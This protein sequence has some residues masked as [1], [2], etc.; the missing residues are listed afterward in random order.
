[1]RMMILLAALPLAACGGLARGS[2]DGVKA[3]SS[4][5]G[6]SR[7]FQVADF[8]GVA[9]EGVDDVD[10]RVGPT[11]SVRADGPSEEL[12]KLNIRKDGSTLRVGRE[13][14]A[15]FNWGGGNHKGVKVHVTMPAIASASVA[16]PG[17]LTVDRVSADSFD[18]S[19]AGPG[20][21]TI[22]QIAAKSADLSVAGPGGITIKGQ[23]AKAKLSIA[24]PGDIH[25]EGLKL[26]QA[27]VSI[28]GPGT[29]RADVNG[30]A[31]VSIMG[32]GNADLGANAKCT[33]SKMGPGEARCG[34]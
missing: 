32:P 15:G 21:L 26:S 8:T 31:N 16:G 13:R 30:P 28:A 5:A 6:G 20:D 3:Q 2:D 19:I 34:S 7:S 25:G 9:L 10:V 23:V 22:G 27:D 17:D 4:G 18:G 29:V 24:G 33:T 1:M 11:F 14:T 12:D